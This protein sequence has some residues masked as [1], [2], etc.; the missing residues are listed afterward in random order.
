MNIKNVEY[1]LNNLIKR[2]EEYGFA[3]NNSLKTLMSKIPDFDFVF[4]EA[5]KILR[6]YSY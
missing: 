4:N 6:S 5:I 1:D 3:W 2:K